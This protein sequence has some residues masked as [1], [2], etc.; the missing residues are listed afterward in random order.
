MACGCEGGSG[1]ATMVLRAGM[2]GDLRY[3]VVDL[4]GRCSVTEAGACV[5]FTDRDE[6]E[7]AA[8][9]V[10]GIV[11]PVTLEGDGA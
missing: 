8:S 7:S 11:Q 6:A 4:D 2:R 1:V 3:V 10:G 9:Q 5:T